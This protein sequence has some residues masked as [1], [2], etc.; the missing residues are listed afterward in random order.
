M[1]TMR[2]HPAARIGS[3]AAT[4]SW[5]AAKKSTSKPARHRAVGHAFEPARGRAAGVVDQ[6]VEASE[7][8]DCRRHDP[9]GG[10]V[11]GHID[12]EGDDP[13]VGAGDV[14]SAASAV[15]LATPS[16]RTRRRAALGDE[17]DRHLAA[18]ASSG[19]GHDRDAAAQPGVHGGTLPSLT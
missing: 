6:D 9:L 17:V 10:I 2:P 16:G 14:A 12:G 4:D 1:F 11:L 8:V 13:A 18:D 15:E 5:A 7:T 3:T 19:A